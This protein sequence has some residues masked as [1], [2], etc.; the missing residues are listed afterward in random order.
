[1]EAKTAKK[2]MRRAQNTVFGIKESASKPHQ[3]HIKETTKLHQRSIK[4]HQT[5]P[6]QPSKKGN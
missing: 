6:T 4:K 5:T 2:V 3:S 1:V